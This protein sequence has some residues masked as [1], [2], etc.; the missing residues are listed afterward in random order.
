MGN[1]HSL[2]KF[3]ENNKISAR[4]VY[5]E[6]N[7]AMIS[8]NHDTNEYDEYNGELYI[9]HIRDKRKCKTKHY[10]VG[11]GKLSFGYDLNLD[12]NN[13]II[14]RSFVE[15]RN[16]A[17]IFWNKPLIRNEEIVFNC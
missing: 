3:E 17:E 1:R 6:T 13:V 4:L 10:N 16:K 7:C 12:G 5:K 8:F 2:D 15:K 11:N 14:K 9:L